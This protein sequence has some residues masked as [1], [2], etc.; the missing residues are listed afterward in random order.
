MLH[1][2][3]KHSN[4]NQ[5]NAPNALCADLVGTVKKERHDDDHDDRRGP[6]DGIEDGQVSSLVGVGQ[7]EDVDGLKNT[8]C[9]KQEPYGGRE[10]GNC[11][12][13]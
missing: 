3:D 7:A 12:A 8:C 6:G 10:C 2:Q 11:R 13:E 5:S 4:D 9:D 1:G